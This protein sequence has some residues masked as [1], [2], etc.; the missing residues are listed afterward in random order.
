M[1]L[2]LSAQWISFME[3]LGENPSRFLFQLLEAACVSWL[4]ASSYLQS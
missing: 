3:A 1:G 4:V 2:K